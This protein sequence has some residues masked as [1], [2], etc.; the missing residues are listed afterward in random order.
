MN[1]DIYEDAI[2]IITDHALAR[3]DEVLPGVIHL[4]PVATR[5]FFPG[6]AVPLVM[7]TAHWSDTIKAAEESSN[8]ILG[9]VLTDAATSEQAT[10]KELRAI[11]TACRI[12]RVQ[13]VEGRLQ[14]LVECLK[15]FR[16]EKLLS[17]EAPFSAQV[18]YFDEP[19]TIS[20]G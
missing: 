20:K 14:V 12:H 19:T 3:P 5:P 15:R 9:I 1:D 4:L 13:Q 10:A 11:G 16:I 2:D 8:G 6:Q 18:R 7:D 17:K